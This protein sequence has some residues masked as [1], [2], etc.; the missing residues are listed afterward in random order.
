MKSFFPFFKKRFYLLIF[1]EKE[2]EG[3]R[4]GEKHQFAR[5]TSLGCLL[6]SPAGD[7]ACNPR[8]WPDQESNQRPFRLQDG[9]QSTEL[10]QSGLFPFL[11][12][13]IFIG[14]KARLKDGEKRR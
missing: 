10:Q 8:M 9:V 3:E 7:L 12:K 11:V 1:R 5:E 6:P 4:E 2:R 14:Q 13:F